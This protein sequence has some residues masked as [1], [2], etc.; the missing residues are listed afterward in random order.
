M[1]F[2]QEKVVTGTKKDNVGHELPRVTAII[3]GGQMGTKTDF[4]GKYSLK[5][6]QGKVLVF[7]FI[8]MKNKEITVGIS[9]K[10]DVILEEDV[11][12]LEEVVIMGYNT[13]KKDVT[14]ANITTVTGESLGK[15][16]PSTSVDNMLQGKASGVDVT[17]LNGKPGQTAT[18]KIRGAVSLNTK[19]GDKAQ[20]LYVIDGVFV[21][22]S[23]LNILNPNDI[24]AMSV[25]KDAASTSI[26]GSR[27][28]NGVI[29]IT[30]KQGKKGG[31][32]ISYSGRTGFGEK[33][34]DRFEI[35]N[36]A[37]KVQYEEAVNPTR[38][39]RTP[40]E[41]ARL[42]S[43][44][45]NWA[46]DILKTAQIISHT[47][48]ASGATD[49]GAYF[50]SGGWDEN[51]GIVRNNNGFSRITARANFST[52]LTEKLKVGLN[53]SVSHTTSEELRD[54]NNIQ[55]PFR[56][57]YVYNPY[58]PVFERD[59]DG[60]IKLDTEGAPIY[61][62]GNQPFSIIE[63]I[64]NAPSL[65]KIT[66]FVANAFAD[67][68][69]GKGFSFKTQYSANYRRYKGE[70]YSKPKSQ[71]DII[72]GDPKSPGSKSDYGR[73]T[74]SYTWLNQLNYVKSFGNHNL[75][76]TVFSEFTEDYFH[77][78]NFANK[79]YNSKLLNTQDNGS[80]PTDT[81]TKKEESVIFSLATAV[82]Y[83]YKGTYLASASIRRDGASRF[84]KNNRYGIFWSGSIGWNITKEEFLQSVEWLNNLKLTASYGTTGNWYIPNYVAQGYY[85]SSSYNDEPVAIIKT[86]IANPDLTWEKQQSLNFGLETSMFSNRLSFTASYFD[87]IRKDF[88]FELSLPKEGGAYTKY[89]NAGKMATKGVELSFN[90]DVLKT[91]D[92]KWSVGGN[93]TFIDYKI[94]SLDGRDN[95]VVSSYSVLK[96][97]ETPFTFYLPKYA[98]VDPN[99]GDALYYNYNA[100]TGETKVVSNFSEATEQVLSGK[101]PLAKQYGGFNT[102]INYKEIDLSADFSFKLGNY[103]YNTVAQ[104]L[105]SD[106][107]GINDNQR[108]DALDYWKKPGDNKLPALNAKNSQTSD[109]FLQD[110]SYLRLRNVTLGYNIPKEW[111]KNANVRVFVQAQNLYTW[112]K[113]EGDPEISIGSG[114]SQLGANQNF[115]PGLISMYSYPMLQTY[116]MG[117]DITF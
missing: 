11:Q 9:S 109:R 2:A 73:D 24:E 57:I 80:K 86:N 117:I 31:A 16:T 81:E 113:F 111:L 51:T 89:V 92:F 54:R 53:S 65:R 38:F 72:V 26:Y 18:I 34:K 19:G 12:N 100:N 33:I 50:L 14:S 62:T 63:G 41:K 39:K 78:Y 30:T 103:S 29:I 66:Q 67:Y 95:I 48:S 108:K 104:H 43:Y 52:K 42:L 83:D 114:E 17:A 102:L 105:L 5:V 40:E 107:K 22:E 58:D 20:P 87:N 35:M 13:R 8:G 96:E 91:T 6:A 60:N 46:D 44:D 23:D 61:N 25:L 28:A 4:D 99:N 59:D 27:G 49:N 82:E 3:K 93:I 47:L 76:A 64:I 98:G 110:A 97:G 116:T 84:G 37:E 112:T 106:G 94:K 68:E 115:V 45:H 90:A 79:G 70:N 10:I 21:S 15:L 56:A 77:S 55:N 75:N 69:V 88:L 36:A 85:G 71:L 7:S 32:K 1:S 74:Y 101:S